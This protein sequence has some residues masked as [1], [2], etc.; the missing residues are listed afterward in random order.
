VRLYLIHCGEAWTEGA[1]GQEGM[2][3]LPQ[4]Y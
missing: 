2:V 4:A 1:D 3:V